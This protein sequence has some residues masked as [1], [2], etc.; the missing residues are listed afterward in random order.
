MTPE[1]RLKRYQGVM[2]AAQRK[3]GIEV[4]LTLSVRQLG[5]AALV[6]PV[7]QLAASPHWVPPGEGSPEAP[8]NGKVK[9]ADADSL[10]AP[11]PEARPGE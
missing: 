2:D 4:Q 1:E 9:E 7:I 10:A 3:Y 5:N 6:E 11:V 8:A